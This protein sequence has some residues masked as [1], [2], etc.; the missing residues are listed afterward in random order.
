MC[1]TFV[2]GINEKTAE[3]LP[4][5]LDPRLYLLDISLRLVKCFSRERSDRWME[6]TKYIIS[7]L[8]GATWSIN[9]NATQSLLNNKN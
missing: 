5:L 4:N 8:R 2:G 7:V 9:I 6:A 3:N 1:T